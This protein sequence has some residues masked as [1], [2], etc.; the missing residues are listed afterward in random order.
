M[1]TLG[2]ILKMAKN[3]VSPVVSELIEYI[4][5]QGEM[6]QDLKDEIAGLKGQKP[7]PKIR[8]SN[9]EKETNRRKKKL[10]NKKRP[11]SKKRSKTKQ[12]EI[13]EDKIIKPD[14]IPEGSIFQGYQGF[15][16]QDFV[17]GSWNIRYRKA[18]YKTPSGDYIIGDLSNQ[19]SKSHFGS[20]LTA[21]ILYQY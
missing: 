2:Q 12:L 21:F 6:I 20:T 4:K 5:Q 16:V 17:I 8:P 7:K 1:K 13:H 11:G 18:R 14:F 9:L 19:I 10:R 3:E 15:I